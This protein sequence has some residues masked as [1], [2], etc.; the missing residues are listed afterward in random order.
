MLVILH[1][2][3]KWCQFIL[4]AICFIKAYHFSLKHLL[5]HGNLIK[6]QQK[7]ISQLQAYDFEILY[8]KD[9]ENIV[10]VAL[11][12]HDEP[13]TFHS[14]PFIKPTWVIKLITNYLQY[15]ITVH[16]NQTFLVASEPTLGLFKE[17]Y[18]THFEKCIYFRP[19]LPFIT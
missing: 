10:V 12:R 11:S 14:T 5:T 18:V 9:K 1:A 8:K 19:S 4:I 15:R 7:W 16:F 2:M 13:P 6:E 3:A 17:N